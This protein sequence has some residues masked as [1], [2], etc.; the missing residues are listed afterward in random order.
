MS[1][2]VDEQGTEAVHAHAVERLTAELGAGLVEHHAEKGDLWVRVSPEAWVQAGRVARDKLGF[3]YF[4]FLSALDWLPSPYGKGEDDPTA[5]PPERS[6]E[7]K[8][9]YAGGQT[10]WQVFAR[11]YSHR[12]HCGITFKVDVADAD[13]R[14][15]T[16]T[17]L[18]AG[19]NWHER[20]T[21]EMFGIV[22]D[23]HPNLTHLYLPHDFEGF[24]LRKD[25]PLLARIVKPWPGIVDVEPMPGEDAEGGDA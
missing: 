16:W 20:E 8:Q 5:P 19:A 14:L 22:F 3:D 24:P 23:G 1:S 9:G 18:F 6:T 11:L 17:E 4:C 21:W 10:R 2:T 25:Y 7:I 12:Q 15:P 13:P